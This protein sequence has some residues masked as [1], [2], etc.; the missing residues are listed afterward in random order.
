MK[1]SA[2]CA[3]A[4][5]WRRRWTR[6]SDAVLDRSSGVGERGVVGGGWGP[7]RGVGVCVLAGGGEGVSSDGAGECGGVRLGAVWA[8]RGRSS[9][10]GVA[11]G[12]DEAAWDGLLYG[13][14]QRVGGGE[15]I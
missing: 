13:A 2:G 4:R 9:D 15:P 7:A 10:D 1:A 12:R 14:G 8:R 3:R 5:G 11:L 6:G